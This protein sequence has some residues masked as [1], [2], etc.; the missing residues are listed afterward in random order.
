[1]RQNEAT[2]RYATKTTKIAKG[3]GLAV[4]VAVR[5]DGRRAAYAAAACGG[6]SNGDF[7]PFVFFVA[8]SSRVVSVARGR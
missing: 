6:P 7:V 2:E 4:I 3:V 1:M 5:F 8:R